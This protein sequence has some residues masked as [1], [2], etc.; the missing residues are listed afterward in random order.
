MAKKFLLITKSCLAKNFNFLSIGIIIS[1]T[2]KV[3]S[4]LD[5][6]HIKSSIFWSKLIKKIEYVLSLLNVQN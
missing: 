1:I 5:E 3:R 6:E 2:K 4:G